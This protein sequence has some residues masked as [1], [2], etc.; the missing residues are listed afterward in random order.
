M[1]QRI[2]RARHA[3]RHV[4]AGDLAE[5]L[6]QVGDVHHVRHR[7][8]RA[9]SPADRRRPA[10]PTRRSGRPCPWRARCRRAASRVPPSVPLSPTMTIIVFAAVRV[11]DQLAVGV[12]AGQP[13]GHQQAAELGVERLDHQVRQHALLAT[14]CALLQS[15]R[16]WPPGRSV[17][18]ACGGCITG[19]CAEAK[20]TVA[21]H[22]WFFG[23]R[24]DPVDGRVDQ[25][26]CRDRCARGCRSAAPARG[27]L[28]VVDDQRRHVVRAQRL[29]VD[30]ST[31]AGS[32]RAGPGSKMPP[33][34]RQV[35]PGRHAVGASCIGWQLPAGRITGAA[36]GAPPLRG[37]GHEAAG[38]AGARRWPRRRP[39]LSIDDGSPVSSSQP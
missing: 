28:P 39:C 17:S 26:R 19:V 31:A 35:R 18:S 3:G 33:L 14:A 2:D 21:I 9:G 30:V 15:G 11:V 23:W 16:W 12:A 10:A 37:A 24:L 29:E 6:V 13:G 4:D 38:I 7:A 22:G 20:L 25:A 5:Q 8:A 32:G 1:R 36:V 27:A 34:S